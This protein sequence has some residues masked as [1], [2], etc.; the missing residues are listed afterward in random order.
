[1]VLLGILVLG[2]GFLNGLAVASAAAAVV[3]LVLAIPVLSLRLGSSDQG[4]D[5]LVDHHPP[6][7]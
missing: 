2:V 1:V 3:M 5:P 4:N 7:V 6:G